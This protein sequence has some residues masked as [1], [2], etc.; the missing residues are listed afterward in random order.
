MNTGSTLFT[1]L[2]S[3]ATQYDFNQCVAKYQGSYDARKFSYW[4][5]FLCMSFAQLTR[6]ESLRDIETCLRGSGVSLYHLG[7][8]G[9]ISRN[10]LAKANENRDYRIYAEYGQILMR[11]AQQ[12]YAGEELE[13][14]L[15][16]A[17]FA[18]DSTNIDL[19][20]SLF[21]WAQFD[22]IRAGLR[23]SS[24]LN[25]RGNIPCF[26]H[27]T[28]MKESELQGMD[29]LQLE[30]GAIYVF[31]RGYFDWK[32]LNEFSK[33][34]AHFVTRAK[35]DLKYRRLS[36]LPVKKET[37][38]RSDQ[39]ITPFSDK[40][41][42][43]FPGVLRRITFFDSTTE[44]RFVFLTNNLVLPPET[45]AALYKS[46][47][48]IELFF[49]W[50]KQHLRI[51]TFLGRSPNAVKIQIWIAISTYLLIAIAKK[52][53]QLPHSFYTISQIL[54]VCA[55]QKIPIKEA[56]SH[57]TLQKNRQ[58]DEKSSNQLHLWG[59]PTGQ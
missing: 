37:G 31:D 24:L 12:Y 1:Q 21:P 19:C 49:K 17:V 48:Q 59:F 3:F 28:T 45:I 42:D 35:A 56:L 50:I 58:S 9:G 46:R 36:S 2:L 33:N 40:A 38:V 6:R 34:S 51:K 32:R 13:V 22:E 39:L 26:M 16:Q 43:N 4:D 52:K 8:R 27:I 57:N 11:E 55:F 44:Q 54:S 47:W 23:V 14:D 10:T 25:L 53:L 18:L 41:Q 30:T 15:K 20:L 29:A 7:I 5:Q